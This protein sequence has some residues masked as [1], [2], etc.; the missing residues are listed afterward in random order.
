MISIMTVIIMDI[1]ETQT[2]KGDTSQVAVVVEEY[3]KDLQAV[4][5]AKECTIHIYLYRYPRLFHF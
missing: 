1:T 4:G 3:P 2:V 5:V